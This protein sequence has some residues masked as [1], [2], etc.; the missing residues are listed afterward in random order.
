M[1]ACL[2]KLTRHAKIHASNQANRPVCGG[3]Y[4]GRSVQWQ[5]E[6]GPHTCAACTIILNKQ[7]E[8]K[9]H[10]HPETATV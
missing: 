5:F 8:R 6:I 3:G 7:H 10:D 4:G 1:S 2:V 9:K